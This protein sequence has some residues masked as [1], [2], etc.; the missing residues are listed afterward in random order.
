MTSTIQVLASPVR[1]RHA[2]TAPDLVD[3]LIAR[4]EHAFAELVR[5]R[6]PRMLAVATRHLR[7][8]ADAEDASQRGMSEATDQTARVLVHATQCIRSLVHESQQRLDLAPVPAP[9]D[10]R[11]LVGEAP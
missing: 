8:A 6:G 2:A 10:A 7:S 11:E 3:R 1:I 9:D 4:D 5:R